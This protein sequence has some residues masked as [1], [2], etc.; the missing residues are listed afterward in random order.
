MSE[1]EEIRS[2][3]GD[4]TAFKVRMGL[5]LTGEE[6]P[7]A[8]VR[9]AVRAHLDVQM[10]EAESG[11]MVVV[12]ASEWDRVREEAASALQKWEKLKAEA[13]QRE[14]EPG[15]QW[16]SQQAPKVTP[17]PAGTPAEPSTNEAQRNAQ[18]ERWRKFN[19]LK[20][21]G[22]QR[23]ENGDPVPQQA[24][25]APAQHE[26]GGVG[27]DMVQKLR[28]AIGTVEHANERAKK[29][30]QQREAN[31]E[32]TPEPWDTAKPKKAA[33]SKKAPVLPDK[34]PA[35]VLHAGSDP[36]DVKGAI[37]TVTGPDPLD[38]EYAT[39]DLAHG[40]YYVDKHGNISGRALRFR[41]DALDLP[42]RTVQVGGNPEKV[43]RRYVKRDI[44][45]HFGS[46]GG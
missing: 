38:T 6:S 19:R 26:E 29:R 30:R 46:P 24:P 23:D 35:D 37:L 3:L 41:L 44:V 28:D 12:E 20:N 21:H 1:L 5:L 2:V 40:I 16:I 17:R 9:D 15:E 42:C 43:R 7:V 22:V 11:D 4:E 10:D 8:Y 33:K 27:E 14:I 13:R 45:K 18:A 32:P 31:G 34:P 39:N 25:A 36:Q